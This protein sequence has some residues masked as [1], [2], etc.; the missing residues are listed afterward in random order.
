MFLRIV[1]ILCRKMLDIDTTV[2][3]TLEGKYRLLGIVCCK[4]CFESLVAANI[5][6]GD[7]TADIH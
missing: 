7:I 1:K 4:G 5:Q 6:L 2:D 3:I